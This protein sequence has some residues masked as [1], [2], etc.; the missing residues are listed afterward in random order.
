MSEEILDLESLD[1]DELLARLEGGLYSL[2]YGE[3]QYADLVKIA[4]A[5]G[6]KDFVNQRLGD[7]G[8]DEV[9]ELFS[10]GE[11]AISEFLQY[12]AE[13]GL[14]ELNEEDEDED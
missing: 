8:R 3:E 10:D 2:F 7:V 4:A 13:K 12:A 5:L 6:I 14:L 9:V 1:R 11:A